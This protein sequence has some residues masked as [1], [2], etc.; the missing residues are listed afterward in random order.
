M[1][2]TGDSCGLWLWIEIKADETYYMR[3]NKERRLVVNSVNEVTFLIEG[4]ATKTNLLPFNSFGLIISLNTASL[5]Q[6]WYLWRTTADKETF[7]PTTQA[8]FTGSVLELKV[9]RHIW[10]NSLRY[11]R[12]LV[13]T[14]FISR[15]LRR[16]WL[17]GSIPLSDYWCYAGPPF[18]ASTANNLGVF[19]WPF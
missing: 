3:D 13:R 1:K 15:A 18:G 16:R 4:W 6:R 10:K 7:L 9:C 8:A 17:A 19:L 14:S 5:S 11:Q 12:P 2:A